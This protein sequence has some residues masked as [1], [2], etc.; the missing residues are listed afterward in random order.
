VYSKIHKQRGAAIVLA[1]LVVSLVVAIVA[2]GFWQRWRI[3]NIE[4]SERQQQQAVWLLTGA[5]DWAKLILLE[6]Y[7][8]DKKNNKVSDHLSEAWSV[9]LEE[10]K[11]STFLA[12]DKENNASDTFDL[13]VFLSGEIQ[14]AQAKLNINNVLKGKDKSKALYVGAF[15]RLFEILELPVDEWE[16]LYSKLKET[17]APIEPETDGKNNLLVERVGDLLALGIKNESLDLLKPHITVL[18]MVTP[19][20]INTA[21]EA[22]LYG[23][24]LDLARIKGWLAQRQS[25]PATSKEVLKTLELQEDIAT[26]STS[27][28][29]LTG[30]IRIEKTTF[31]QQILLQRSENRVRTISKRIGDY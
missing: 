8:A 25:E 19:V 27:T 5:I 11:L 15:K 22:V 1:M 3:I 21:G 18:P 10:A 31:V 20:N 30:R 16:T 24:G 14:D 13:P 23:V 7:R 2:N 26:I 9:P 6:D 28:F 12:M 17:T 4:E 29:W